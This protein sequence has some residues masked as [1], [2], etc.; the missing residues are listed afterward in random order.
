[1][2]KMNLA[3]TD[4]GENAPKCARLFSTRRS[5]LFVASTRYKIK[6]RN[7]FKLKSKIKVRI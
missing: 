3:L 2:I 7:V 1:M 6:A 5:A 4:T